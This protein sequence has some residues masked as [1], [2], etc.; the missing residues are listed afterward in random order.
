MIV[1]ADIEAFMLLPAVPP[2]YLFRRILPFRRPRPACRSNSP[3]VNGTGGHGLLLLQHGHKPAPGNDGVGLEEFPRG[4]SGHL[5]GDDAG[6]L[7][8]PALPVKVHPDGHL[9]EGEEGPTLGEKAVFPRCQ[10]PVTLP[11]TERNPTVGRG[12]ATGIGSLK[13][14]PGREQEGTGQD[15]PGG[16]AKVSV[17]TTSDFP[18]PVKDPD[19]YRRFPCRHIFPILQKENLYN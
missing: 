14:G 16:R 3:A 15:F 7:T 8:F 9:V 2:Y 12:I 10:R 17:K 4:G 5:R 11:G 18:A 19:P 1:G 6:Q 13:S